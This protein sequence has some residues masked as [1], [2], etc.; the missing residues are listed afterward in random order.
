M[1]GNEE[2]GE[3]EC[4]GEGGRESRMSNECV[5]VLLIELQTE[6]ERGRK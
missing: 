1:R 6:K 3:I 2:E 5:R 4:V